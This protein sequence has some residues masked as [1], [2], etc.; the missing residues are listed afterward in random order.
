MQMKS[1][2]KIVLGV[3]VVAAIVWAVVFLDVRAFLAQALEWVSQLGFWGPVVFVLVYIASTVLFLPG[4]LLTLGAG[5]LFGIVRGMI[6][7]SIGSTLGATLAFLVSRYFAR[8]WI[9]RKIEGNDKF[10]AMDKAVGDEGWKIVLLTRLSP[11]FPFNFLNYAYGITRV[12]L[13]HYFFASWLGM[14]PGTVLYVYIGSLAGSLAALEEEGRQR[15]P[16]EWA[17]YGFGFL[18]AVVVT[19]Y[20]TR[21]A[22]RTLEEKNI[23]T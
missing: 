2:L 13:R 23:P 21:L 19:I 11:I 4:S 15:T 3:T 5:F 17:F 12:S 10:R 6:I 20:V 9:A 8:D 7:I 18:A 22:R 1:G 14:L 16:M